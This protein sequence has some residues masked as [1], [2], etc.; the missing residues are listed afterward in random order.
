MTLIRINQDKL[1]LAQAEYDRLKSLFDEGG[2]AWAPSL[3][4]VPFKF[5]RLFLCT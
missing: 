5:Y 4:G 3:A 2:I 1:R